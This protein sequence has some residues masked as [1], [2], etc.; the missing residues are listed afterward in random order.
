MTGTLAGAVTIEAED[1]ASLL[2]GTLRGDLRLQE[3][4]LAGGDST[5]SGSV[6]VSGPVNDPRLELDL[7]AG[8]RA[9]GR[10]RIESAPASGRLSLRSDLSWGPLTTD[11]EVSSTVS[12][13]SAAGRI[14]LPG[15]YFVLS[16][17]ARPA[18]ST[19]LPTIAL[20]GS[21]RFR[22]WRLEFAPA[23]PEL[24][25]QADLD[26]LGNAIH[27]QLTLNAGSRPPGEPW[28][29]AQVESLGWGGV[30]LGTVRLE[31]ASPGAEILIS[32]PD[33]QASVRPRE[34][35][36]WT[37]EKLDLDL[38]AGM[39]ATASGSGS[40]ASGRL[41]AVV[42][43]KVGGVPASLP[44]T[45]E[46]G[47]A[48]PLTVAGSGELLGGT[49]M[50]DAGLV[51]V[52]AE[53][54]SPDARW[55]GPEW[56]GLQWKGEVAAH[57]VQFAGTSGRF[58]GTISGPAPSPQLALN[59]N[60]QGTGFT[61]TGQAL[62]VVDEQA[63]QLD[64]DS[65]YLDSPLTIA[66]RAGEETSVRISGRRTGGSDG[67]FSGSPDEDPGAAAAGVAVLFPH[68][69]GLVPEVSGNLIVDIGP[70]RLALNATSDLSGAGE[71]EAAPGG[72]QG[73]EIVL[74]L[75]QLP[76]SG[77][78]T[79][80]SASELARPA[81]LLEGP[82]PFTG[83]ERTSGR[84]VADLARLSLRVD[85][86]SYRG[87]IATVGLSGRVGP[88]VSSDLVG[89]IVIDAPVR[90]GLLPA[91]PENSR[92]PFRIGADAGLIEVESEGDLGT[93]RLVYDTDVGTADL[94]AVIRF[95]GGSAAG[96][97]SFDPVIG[98]VGRF[99]VDGLP[100]IALDDQQ[101]L[102]LSGD[103]EVSPQAVTGTTQLRA[104]NGSL[105]A[106]AT[107]GLGMF[108]PAAIAP[109]G[110]GEQRLD[111][112][113][114]TFDLS[115]L[116]LVASRVPYLSAPLSGFL[117]IQG[118]NV[119]GRLVA[120]DL[121]VAGETL[122]LSIDVSGP[123]DSLVMN[124][125]V[126]GSAIRLTLDDHSLSALATLERFPLH[127]MVE[128]VTGPTDVS[129]E[130]TGVARVV[131]PFDR[132][133]GP[134]VEVATELVRLERSGVV[135]TGN[136]S[137]VLDEG[138]LNVREAEFNGAGRWSA[139]GSISPDLLD[140]NLTAEDADFGPLLGL[141]PT[142]AR[143]RVAAQG[144]LELSATGT[145]TRPQVTLATPALQFEV[146]GSD[147]LLEQG[148]A[149]L[150]DGRL[151][152]AARVTGLSAVTG[153]LVVAG[154]GNLE[155][156]PLRLNS[157]RFT[158]RGAAVVPG[159]GEISDFEAAV[160]SRPDVGLWLEGGGRLGEP[161]TMK[162]GLA[163]L[164]LEIVGED[165]ALSF[166]QLLLASAQADAALR[167]RWD[168]DLRFSGDLD[169][170][171]ARFELGIRPPGM[172]E[173]RAE[174][175][176]PNPV[177][178]RFVFDDVA[179]RAPG[180]VRFSENF[181]NAELALD[182]TLAGNAA[183]P[184]LNGSAQ[185]LRGTFQFS[186][187]DFQIQSAEARFDPS[188][189]VLPVLDVTA[190]TSFEMRRVQ[191]GDGSV[192]FV[193]PQD[194]SRFEVVLAFTGEVEPLPGESPPFRLDLTP[195]LSSEA[196][197]QE[198]RG[199]G[200]TSG[201][202]SLSEPEL[203]SLI[204]LGRLELNAPLAGQQGLATAVAEGAI[205]TAVDLLIVSELQ[206]ALA[207]A[208]GVEV[209]EI[210]TTALSS[211]FGRDA[212]DPFSVS[213]RLGGYLSDEIFASYQIGSFD[214]ARGLYALTNEVS[215]LYELGPLE[216]DLA[217]RVN[218]ED[219]GVPNPDAEV[220]ATVRYAFDTRTSLE[221]GI[222]LSDDNQ[223]LRFGVTLRW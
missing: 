123:L 206:S 121:A 77:L 87:E 132:R 204:T 144:S 56:M 47:P 81:S 195:S 9:G 78:S 14:D 92:V 104:A 7:L 64:L 91:L 139:E 32:G 124:A 143:Y 212:S 48:S 25:V 165:L 158:A 185:V 145:M 11:L 131:L 24:R 172:D 210:R 115:S 101:Q 155:L 134:S 164:D 194:G 1:L 157:A 168:D 174:R 196:L 95:A 40:A 15:G 60:A 23:G 148:E 54:Q 42:S 12:E 122:P 96:E 102:R 118:R 128:A 86:L 199:D 188:R 99:T 175:R 98:P 180:R 18:D 46:R 36:A 209:V 44:L 208:L 94:D 220:S 125:L 170:D 49:L 63:L 135:T 22:D 31:T 162:G 109:Q 13:V 149:N 191:P 83:I 30:T 183:Q 152:V 190:V 34:G 107:L 161:F 169:I 216:L 116:P 108:V 179:L 10:L 214:D 147:F 159:L 57:G 17:I 126:A 163:P 41:D 176:G 79:V 207:E 90:T 140:F 71:A 33:L 130:V 75:P 127:R 5:L 58:T 173:R 100:L 84:V 69:P 138:A 154:E 114:A 117:Q 105:R 219:T 200:I 89:N 52:P 153:Q 167:L 3:A 70:L 88:G 8:G 37:I 97:L 103:V 53:L 38:P 150:N 120:P 35:F 61:L 110:T 4:G 76:G 68:A 20:D 182:L 19:G 50:V 156:L 166:P 201:P 186:G 129:A 93:V 45:L 136:V 113:L 26:T 66:A 21:D 112:Q 133:E 67:E 6:A 85:D 184:Q 160:T 222:D 203:L 59:A 29:Q 137:L 39:A 189:G 151:A 16:R 82:L 177:A 192:R 223:Q 106:T 111:L 181:G 27:G 141:V 74:S 28:L 2:A 202:R 215:L 55:Q 72:Q 178:E 217:G 80:L 205:D 43:G 119:V 221:A 197:I 51:A 65:P 218:F 198:V 62:L 187:R 73:L 142:L 193:A 171:Q 213:L 146:A 211:V